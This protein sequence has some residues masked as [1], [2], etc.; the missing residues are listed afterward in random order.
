MRDYELTLVIDPDLGSDKQKD[1]LQK[2]KKT[3]E[4][5]KGKVN[6][7]KEWGKRIL[8]YPIKK[9]EMGYYFLWEINF[10]PTGLKKLEEKLKLEENLLRYLIVKKE[11]TKKGGN[12]K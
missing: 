5:L 7:T 11:K 8:A 10:D 4:E 3:L 6:K 12:K 9:K 2:I 1:F